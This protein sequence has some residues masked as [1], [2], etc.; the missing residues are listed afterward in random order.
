MKRGVMTA[1]IGVLTTLASVQ[2]QEVVVSDSLLNSIEDGTPLFLPEEVKEYDGFLLDMSLLNLSM[3]PAPTVG[4]YELLIPD[5]S[6]EWPMLLGLDNGVT[7]GRGSTTFYGVTGGMHGFHSTG[8]NLLMSS[9][10]LK[11]GMRLNTYG[12]YNDQGFRMA[13]PSALPWQRNNFKGAFELKSAN[14]NFGIRV[15]VQRGREY[16]F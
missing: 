3:Q 15:E 16:P 1:I 4:N 7:Y 12:Q 14:G 10:R 11:N 9:F 8:S 6:K 5:A 13:D 2:A